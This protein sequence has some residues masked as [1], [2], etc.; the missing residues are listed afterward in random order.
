MTKIVAI[1][2]IGRDL[3]SLGMLIGNLLRQREE[4]GHSFPIYLFDH[5]QEKTV[6]E[7]AK[8]FEKKNVFVYGKKERE[9]LITEV[10]QKLGLNM[11][12]VRK[13]FSNG[14]GG[15]R[16]FIIA[17]T[18]QDQVVSIDDG[19]LPYSLRHHRIKS[20]DWSD[21][22]GTLHVVKE[23]SCQKEEFDLFGLLTEP[24]G[25]SVSGFNIK[26]G[27][28]LIRTGCKLEL[29]GEAP[30]ENSVIV[31]SHPFFSGDND[32]ALFSKRARATIYSDLKQF[33]VNF[34]SKSAG[35]YGVNNKIDSVLPFVPTTL[36]YEDLLRSFMASRLNLGC[37]L[38]IGKDV[39][40]S[41][42]HK[43][44]PTT[45]QIKEEMVAQ[46]CYTLMGDAFRGCRK[47]D[48]FSSFL[49]KHDFFDGRYE[50]LVFQA[51]DVAG[52][53]MNSGEYSWITNVIEREIDL[54][55][56]TFQMWGKVRE[57]LLDG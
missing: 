30:K 50:T 53:E 38:Y 32:L 44:K 25:K 7:F 48:S 13:T 29:E 39:L 51:Y 49:E 54:V 35:C 19:I 21:C 1:P 5:T 45:G 28:R 18:L 4:Y 37:A 23:S 11:D 46:I 34:R 56:N 2:T 55:K 12:Y 15:N 20:K 41:N 10:S 26:K 6:S 57:Y 33:I 17:K 36:R 31:S 8:Q 27:G 9:Q 3:V 16:N 14:Y 22:V 47:M 42:K 52:L 43:P 40:H 24:L